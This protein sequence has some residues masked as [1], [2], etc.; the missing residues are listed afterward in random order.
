MEEQVKLPEARAEFDPYTILTKDVDGDALFTISSWNKEPWVDYYH[1]LGNVDNQVGFM[2]KDGK[3][4]VAFIADISPQ[5]NG[6]R[7][8]IVPGHNKIPKSLYESMMDTR[9]I[10][11][12]MKPKFNQTLQF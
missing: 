12:S 9:A 5:V 1:E 4:K 7:W 10:A 2:D 6:V 3:H 11:E 8:N